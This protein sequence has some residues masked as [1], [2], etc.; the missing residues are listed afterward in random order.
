MEM[1]RFF[2][3]LPAEVAEEREAGK[4]KRVTGYAARFYNGKPETE[5]ELWPGMVERIM[6]GAFK[7]T[8]KE[9][10]DVVALFNHNPDL[11]LGRRSAKTLTLKVDDDGLQYDVTPGDTAV[12][13]DVLEHVRRRDVV[14]SSFGFLVAP[15]GEKTKK[16][17]HILI[18]ELHDVDLF[19]VGPVT[20]PAY[21]ATT[22][23]VR[24][25]AGEALKAR[26]ARQARRK[27]ILEDLEV[28][29]LAGILLPRQ[30]RG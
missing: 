4:G 2:T 15:D 9:G 19:D 21:E 12:G 16:E 26:E 18:R 11:I 24:A 17:G 28:D 27:A 1:R 5:F 13:R 25:V 8:L 6:P 23:K 10:P 3:L 14:G 22:A 30:I 20:N 29:V 7:R